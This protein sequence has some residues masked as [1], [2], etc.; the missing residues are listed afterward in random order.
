MRVEVRILGPGGAVPERRRDEPLA[1][2][3][4]GAA[5]AAANDARLALEVDE[6]G[7]PGGLVCLADLAADM[8]VVGEGVQETDALR[9]RED[10]VVARNRGQPLALV[11]PLTTLEVER[12]HRDRPLP[13]R[14]AQTRLARGVDPTKQRP[15]VAVSNDTREPERRAHRA[16]PDPRRLATAGVVVVQ[17]V[18]DLLLV[19]GLLPQ[20]QLRHAQHAAPPSRRDKTGTQMHHRCP[21][22]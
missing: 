11:T 7:L 12:A 6:R 16:C 13:H 1:V 14:R 18:G 20:R 19:V 4:G 10:E 5:V 9:T 21:R 15:E 22:C 8:L 2:L 17:A 3:T